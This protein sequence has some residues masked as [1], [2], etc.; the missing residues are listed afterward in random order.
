MQRESALTERVD[1]GR[2]ATTL[3]AVARDAGVSR[4]TVSRVVN[5]SP[6]VSPE[7]RRTVERA[8]DRL[9]YVPN[10]AAR[11]LV[12]RRSDSIGV[13]ITEP[14]SQLFNDPFFPR[15]LRGISA[16]LSAR[17]LQLVLLMPQ[18]GAD[19]E[20]LE[21]YL[22][23]GHVDG[24][25]LV[26]LHANDPLP[27]DLHARGIPFVIGGR[28]AGDVAASYVDVDNRDGARSAVRH[29]TALGRRRIATIT[30]PTDMSVGIDRLEG[31]RD[32][33]AEAGLV[34]DP[35]L[36]ANADFTYEGGLAAMR[37]LLES[38]PD[39]DAVFAASDHLAAGALGAIRSS[40]R[41]VPGDVALVGFDDSAIA[42][43]TDPP[44][45]SVRQPIEDMGGELVRLL[46]EAIERGGRTTRH[47]LLS[48]ELITRGS[49][50]PARATPGRANGG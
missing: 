15:L 10:L 38:R 22:M 42:E 32:A 9:G 49:S 2:A 35:S 5:G 46:A 8:I 48:T 37:R 43:A 31:Y 21:R 47:V 34:A 40:G 1:K 29:L 26:S 28:P 33:L 39:L 17:E 25:I 44:L 14:T 41:S 11:Q 4:A 24:V 16:E 18:N 7:V 50:Q 20:R 3:E 13:V 6:K 12:T 36:E 30:G 23:S 27:G 19:E 45:T